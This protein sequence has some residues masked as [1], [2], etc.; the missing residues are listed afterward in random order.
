MITKIEAL[1]YR[2]LRY[3]RQEL[4]NFQ[5]LVGPNASGKSAFLDVVA[6]QR[7]LLQKGLLKAVQE[8]APDVMSLIWMGQGDKFEIASELTFPKELVDRLPNKDYNRAR[9]EVAV[10]LNSDKEISILGEALWLK[11]RGWTD[12]E[13]RTQ[14]RFPFPPPPPKTI[15]TPGRRERDGWKRVAH[16]ISRSGKDYFRSEIK[17]WISPFRLGPHKSILANI[18]ED[19]EQFPVGTWIKRVLMEGVQ[20]LALNSEAMRRS[21]PPGS[22]IEFQFDGSNLPWVI[23]NLEK[24]NKKSFERWIAHLRTVLPDL[25]KIE[26]VERGEDRH[27]YLQLTYTTGFKAPSW[28][29]SDG[30][31]RLLALTLIA[32]L[33]ESDKIYLIEEPENGIHPMAIESLLQSLTSSY[34]SQILCATH[35]PVVLNEVEPNKILCF[36]KEEGAT[37]ICRGNDH[38]GLKEWRRGVDLGTL[39]A[40]GVLG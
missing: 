35:S 30:T 13:P 11:P 14:L 21:S 19:E 3:V 38:P 15:M 20:R 7:D 4:D 23:N 24:K 29:T 6:F 39:F 37:D 17:R 12:E 33:D 2:C 22:P 31:L 8:R 28:A 5:I 1:N 9:Y 25:R 16:K 36:A 27:R 18:P 26:T 40:S 32:Y 10:G 34:R